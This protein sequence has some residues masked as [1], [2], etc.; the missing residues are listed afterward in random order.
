MALISELKRRNVFRVALLYLVAGWVMLQVAQ[1]LEGVLK[2][3]DWTPRL[4]LGLLLLGL[5]IAL[6][7]SWVYELTPE[8]LK[9]EHEVDRN[10]SAT[11]TTA[12]KLDLMVGALLVLAI[13]M[14]A[15]DRF[16]GRVTV[17]PG[18]ASTTAASPGS[19]VARARSGPASIAVLPFVN[20]SEDKANDYFSD[21]LTEELL[22]VLAKVPGLRVIARTSSFAFKGKSPTIADVAQ[23]LGVDHVL[24]GSVRKSG[25][26][27]RI[28][29]QLI[30]ASDSSHLWSETYDRTL[31]DVFAIQDEISGQVVDALK[32]QLLGKENASPEL[33]GTSNSQAYETYLQG[34]YELNKGTK[35]QTLVAALAE[36]RPRR[37]PGPALRPCALGPRAHADPARPPTGSSPSTRAS[38]GR[39][40][41]RR[42]PS[43]SSPGSRRPGCHSATSPRRSIS[44][45]TP[46][47]ST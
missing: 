25:D 23:A 7:F 28:T 16:T 10:R 14:L 24:E 21:G 44:T 38:S 17:V 41:R 20:M 8:G 31:K 3:P 43:R 47:R 42:L 9:R 1:L 36:L 33:G 15:Y 32:V 12:R 27:V 19:P 37:C 39:V 18:A 11:A 40:R 29:A 5:P 45:S 22:N 30:R 46:R 34:L 2:L 13:G 35:Q 6:I 4:V 26:R